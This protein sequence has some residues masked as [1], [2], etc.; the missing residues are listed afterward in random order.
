LD[1]ENC[2]YGVVAWLPGRLPDGAGG[3]IDIPAGSIVVPDMSTTIVQI[4]PSDGTV[5]EDPILNPRFLGLSRATLDG[6]IMHVEDIRDVGLVSLSLSVEDPTATVIEART[7][8][9]RFTGAG[10]ESVTSDAPGKIIVEVKDTAGASAHPLGPLPDPAAM[11]VFY[12]ANDVNGVA[13]GTSVLTWPNQ[14]TAGSAKNLTNAGAGAGPLHRAVDSEDGLPF[15]EG[16]G[17]DDY[18]KATGLT[19]YTGTEL[20]GYCVSRGGWQGGATTRRDW[21][22]TKIGAIDDANTATIAL[23]RTTLYRQNLKRNTVNFEV[24]SST[25]SSS[26]FY[27]GAYTW[28]VFAWR[29]KVVMGRGV[30]TL[31]HNNRIASFDLGA[32][33]LTAFDIRAIFL[34]AGSSI[35]DGVTAD[36]FSRVDMRHFS[37]DHSAP[38]I[39]AMRDTIRRLA[40]DWA[41]PLMD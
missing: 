38:T 36:L 18:L 19:A 35:G 1:I 8:R 26:S 24:N 33:T 12:D 5:Y 34:F 25:S 6:S 22:L 10:I 3:L 7:D 21:A 23:V 27:D 40:V 11:E 31:F 13:D 15:V 41:V 32:T 9:I 29:W 17:V 20:H 37:Y 30:L 4:D 16:D 14:G 2:T 28:S 39:K